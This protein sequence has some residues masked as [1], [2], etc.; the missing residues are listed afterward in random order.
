MRWVLWFLLTWTVWAKPVEVALFEGGE[1]LDYFERCAREVGNVLCQG[2]PR[3]SEKLRIR[4]LEGKPPEV[5]NASLPFDQLIAKGKVLPLDTWLDGPNWE[6]SGRWRDDF[7]PGSL[8]RFRIGGHTYGIPLQ[9]TVQAC[10]YS[11][12]NFRA[13]GWQPPQTWEQWVKLCSQVESSGQAALA[14][15]GRYTYYASP[16]IQHCYYYLAGPQAYADQF[17]LKPGSFD[18]PAMVEALT[19]VQDLARG[20]FQPGALG[21]SHTEAQMEFLQG[22]AAMIVCGSW[23]KSE[24]RDKIPAGFEL[25]EFPL[26]PPAASN[27]R[28][29]AQ[30]GAGYFFVFADSQQPAGG[31]DYLRYITAPAQA[32]QLVESQDL[33]VAVRGAN[34]KLSPDLQGLQQILA[35]SQASFGEGLAATHPGMAQIWAD[36]RFDLLQGKAT[37]AELARRLEAAAARLSAGAEKAP[38]LFPLRPWLLLAAVLCLVLLG[39]APH[40]PQT[41]NLR[42]L[43]WRDAVWLAGPPLLLYACFFWLPGLSALLASGCE[44]DGLSSPHWVGA[45]NFRNLLESSPRFW[46]ALGNNLFLMACIPTLITVWSLLFAILLQPDQPRHRFLR[47]L[48]FLPNLLG[49]GAILIWQQIYHPQGPLNRLL[50]WDNFTW[51]SQDHLYPSML[52]LALWSAGG[53]QMVLC[54]AALSQVPS[55][56]VD[57]ARIEGANR[58]Q[59]FWAVSW[60]SLRPTVL[61]GYFLLLIGAVKSFDTIWLFTN[62]EPTSQVHVLGTLL[63]QTAFAE[64]KLGEATA[65]AVI[66]LMLVLALQRALNR[67]E[68]P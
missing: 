55:E 20:H 24:M 8:D 64:L 34:Q 48:Y 33:P 10:Y 3:I 6:R 51:L 68:E 45:A 27:V 38:V 53:F 12:A 22:H 4:L 60:P 58:W 36:V 67:L 18:N 29:A 65:L 52:P 11:R 39:R 7:L 15:Q 25:A 62:Q 21:M 1:G 46:Q 66:L 44:W 61:A 28:P 37:P 2:D 59:Q 47:A 41:A 9:Y 50:G 13:H 17:A 57:A 35:H 42:Q 26:P 63:V 23:F 49:I 30:V 54:S 5:T 32:A 31:V 14:F 16:L 40:P 56:L 43:P 19:R